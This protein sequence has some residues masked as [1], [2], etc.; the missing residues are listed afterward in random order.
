VAKLDELT[1]PT[2]C[3]MRILEAH[4]NSD[5]RH[6]IGA[7]TD[8]LGLPVTPT[9]AHNC[10]AIA[11]G[12]P[13]PTS[14]STANYRSPMFKKTLLGRVVFTGGY[15]LWA[16]FVL[17]GARMLLNY[18][19]TSGT[20]A[21][22]PSQWP[23]HSR[24]ARPNSR[25]T[26]VMLAHPNCPC[27]RASLAEL[28]ILM[29]KLHGKL[30]AFVIFSKPEAGAKEV[31]GSDL[32]KEAATIPDVRAVYDDRGGETQNF[33]GQVSGQTLLYNPK[34]RLVFSGGITSAR[35]HQGD[36]AGVD[37]VIS[38]VNG[39]AR[40]P[41]HTPAFGCALHNPGTAELREGSLWKK[42]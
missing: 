8:Q 1:E 20:P 14:Q 6:V 5:Y 38:N 17:F 27:T 16:G 25:F 26:L 39:E 3:S 29:A 18:E 2:D 41:G 23:S 35:G 40:V 12:A 28:N 36:N 37:A 31:K 15:L 13:L 11:D 42:Q 22:A 9:A 7:H 21:D 34:G 32:W 33:G 4:D 24:I 19:N 10:G 30:A